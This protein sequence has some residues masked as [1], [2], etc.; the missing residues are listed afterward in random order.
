MA[1]PKKLVIAPDKLV[2][3]LVGLGRDIVID[4]MLTPYEA[5]LVGI[6]LA[7]RMSPTAARQFAEALVKKAAE[8]EA[9]AQ[10]G[11]RH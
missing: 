7:I 4:L 9:E 11:S 6:P 8:A 2:L 3:N 1:D 5:S 10:A